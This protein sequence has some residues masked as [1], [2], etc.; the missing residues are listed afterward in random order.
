MLLKSTELNPAV[1][2]LTEWKNEFNNLSGKLIPLKIPSVSEIK[3]RN[4]FFEVV[5]YF[6]VLRA[7]FLTLTAF[8]A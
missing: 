7:H 5:P 8:D 2:A 4:S 6:D 3:N 1:L